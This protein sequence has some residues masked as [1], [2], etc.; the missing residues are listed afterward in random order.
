MSL[1]DEILSWQPGPDDAGNYPVKLL[2]SDGQGGQ[3][4]GEYTLEVAE[5]V[6]AVFTSTPPAAGAEG[7][8]YSYQPVV[9]RPA[10]RMLSFFL[11][12]GFDPRRDQR[13]H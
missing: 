1:V 7:E 13:R 6:A 3:A 12:E 5:P 10:S 8:T 9:E 11:D 4:V 2:V